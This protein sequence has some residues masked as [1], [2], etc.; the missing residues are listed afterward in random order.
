MNRQT[1]LSVAVGL[2]TLALG[3]LFAVTLEVQQAM[4][5]GASTWL[6]YVAE[7]PAV[8]RWRGVSLASARTTRRG[9]HDAF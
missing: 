3:A 9:G 2:L 5:T 1:R 4:G 8:A 6:P 7:S